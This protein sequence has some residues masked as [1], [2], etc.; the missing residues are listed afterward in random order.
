MNISKLLRLG[1]LNS[2]GVLRVIYIY[3]Y[4]NISKLLRLICLREA[5]GTLLYITRTTAS[6][7]SSYSDAHFT[8]PKFT[9]CMSTAQLTTIWAL[10]KLCKYT[11]RIHPIFLI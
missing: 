5:Q 4:M 2:E 9:A 8:T 1:V 6:A 10:F 3:T 7:T 11:P